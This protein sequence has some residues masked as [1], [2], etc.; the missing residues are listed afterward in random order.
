MSGVAGGLLIIPLLLGAIPAL[1]TVLVGGALLTAASVVVSVGRAYEENRRSKRERIQQSKAGEPMGSFREDVLKE[2]KDQTR[3][4]AEV[5]DRMIAELE[6]SRQEVSRVL[7]DSDP[8]KY[9]EYLNR[10]RDS[11]VELNNRLTEMQTEF[12][13]NYRGRAAAGL[14]KIG[15][16]AGERQAAHMEDLRSMQTSEAQK[17]ELTK[18]LAEQYLQEAKTLID[19]LRDDFDGEV[20]SGPRLASLVSQWNGAAEQCS[21][22]RRES[23][24][25]VA[26]NVA[27]SA[28]EEIY[29]AD[30]KKQEWENYHKLALVQANGIKSYLEAQSVITPEIR[31]ELEE[32]AG[33]EMEQEL[34]GIK[35]GDYT[36]VMETGETQY[37]F[38]LRTTRE[39][40]EELDRATPAKIPTA[41]L[42]RTLADLNERLY[43]DA[44]TVLYKGMLNMNNAF[45]R[46]RLSEEII[47]FFEEHDFTFSGYDY[48][49]DDHGKAL[50][51]GLENR[52]TGEDLVVTLAPD[53]TSSGDIRT[54]VKIDQ[55][56]GDET[57][58]ER[59]AYYRQAVQEVVAENLPGARLNIECDRSTR[60]KLS[61]NTE[62]KNRLKR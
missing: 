55:M 19:S 62:L 44:M 7:E 60:N 13:K 28:I 48:E 8:G 56:G 32:K 61:P 51:I 15:R 14:E 43:P 18:K 53:V 24:I 36:D 23:S 45:T 26:K 27:L 25:A 33:R 4:N 52:V 29:D 34:V 9:H 35:P 12:V 39:L 21:L 59:K 57:N 54:Q 50:Y 37:D 22:G 40:C 47:D 17:D 1:G 46:Q 5:S 30:C 38:L 2:M 20:F 10:I 58:E 6:R 16:D 49:N 11:R 31:R 3:L 42:K 41:H